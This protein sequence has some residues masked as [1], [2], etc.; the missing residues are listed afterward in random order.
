MNNL[1][2]AQYPTA[3]EKNL[4][5]SQS[6]SHEAKI[7]EITEIIVA[8]AQDKIAFI[9]LFGPFA[10]GDVTAN[11]NY[12]FLILTKDKK[13]A[14]RNKANRLRKRISDAINNKTKDKTHRFHLTI[15]PVDYANS[16]TNPKRYF[17]ADIKRDGILLYDSGEF[18]LLRLPELEIN[19]EARIKSATINY[20]HLLDKANDFMKYF[21]FGIDNGNLK[22]VAFNLH[23]A[24]ETLFNCTILVFN[25]YEPRTHDLLEL[26]KLCSANSNQFLNI[27]LNNNAEEKRAFDLLRKAYLK[28]RYDEQYEINKNQLE[29]LAERVR[30]LM[31]IVISNCEQ[32]INQ[33][34]QRIVAISRSD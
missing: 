34:L 29:Y 23:Q 21:Q 17:F 9:I 27:F 7:K 18:E 25:G 28:A 12:N 31:E 30:I 10:C 6:H 14:N 1:S 13:Y 32:R 24:A 19:S 22:G 26:N 33:D 11:S 16:W 3:I 4:L 5:P 20:C 2:S 15:E 8:T